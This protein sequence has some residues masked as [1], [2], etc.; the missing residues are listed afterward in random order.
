MELEDSPI[1]VVTPFLLKVLFV[2]PWIEPGL[3]LSLSELSDIVLL[4]GHWTQ[5]K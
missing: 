5:L 3:M 1:W 4:P 2:D